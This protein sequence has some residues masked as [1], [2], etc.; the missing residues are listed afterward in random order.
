ML[1]TAIVWGFISPL[2]ADLTGLG[3]WFLRLDLLLVWLAFA[4]ALLVWFRAPDLPVKLIVISLVLLGITQLVTA[5]RAGIPLAGPALSF[6]LYGVPFAAISTLVLARPGRDRARLLLWLL[7]GLAVLQFLIS[8]GQIPFAS[9]PDEIFGMFKG[10]LIAPHLNGAIA[11]AVALWILGRS[12]DWRDTLWAAPFVLVTILSDT[13]QALFLLPFALALSPALNFKVWAV[14]LVLPVLGTLLALWAPSIPGVIPDNYGYAVGEIERAIEPPSEKGQSR[15]LSGLQETTERV[16]ASPGSLAFGLGQGQSVG[17][18]ALLSNKASDDSV[19][20]SLGL[21]PSQIQA[22]EIG[23]WYGSGSFS[24]EFSSMVGLFGDLGLVGLIAFGIGV[25][26][27]VLLVLRTPGVDRNAVWALGLY[28]LAMG[29]VYIWW[30]QP[31]FTLFLG[32]LMGAIF[33]SGG[34]SFGPWDWR[35]GKTA[36]S[37]D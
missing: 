3:E 20:R 10:I 29:L 8:V 1:A 4:I 15:K 7:F 2:L 11:G 19:S 24:S 23:Y 6:A 25:A 16:T 31:V 34:R 30:E 18:I 32:L 36:R 12:T 14:R 26:G 27:V 28:Y 5:F 33:A 21:E 13:K 22:E 35:S 17:Y 9:H 37:P